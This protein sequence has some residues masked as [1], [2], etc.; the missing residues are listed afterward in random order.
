[1]GV[2][3]GLDVS[4]ATV[5]ICIV[6]EQGRCVWQGRTDSSPDAVI[7]ALEPWQA[8]LVR[9]GLEAGPTSE[10]IGGRLIE[11]G[12]PAVCQVLCFCSWSA[13]MPPA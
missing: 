13:W 3:A 8:D 4:L 7:A 2:F 10:W 1:M 12:F 5:A 11:A 6:D 9:V